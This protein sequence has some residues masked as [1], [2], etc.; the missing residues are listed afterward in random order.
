MT[1]V[2]FV[3]PERAITVVVDLIPILL[4]ARYSF[5]AFKPG[6]FMVTALTLQNYVNVIVDPYYRAVLATTISMALA[7]TILSLVLG[8][9]LAHF[10]SRSVRYKKALILLVIIPLFFG[11]AVRAASWM[12][13]LGE[14]G[15]VN[16]ALIK[17]HLV[18]SPLSIMFTPAAVLIGSR[19]VNIPFV[20]LT[21]QSVLE[22]IGSSVEEAASSLRATPFEVFRK[23]TWP[24]ALAGI[25]TPPAISS[26]PSSMASAPPP[27]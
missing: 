24:L 3:A 14:Q 18:D 8:I 4:I 27:L 20:V 2:G 26:L 5:N 7:V 16:A 11:N 23:V 9:P 15:L 25:K 6:E 21:I 17:L 13:A 10:I 19:S 1:D 22:G 12:L